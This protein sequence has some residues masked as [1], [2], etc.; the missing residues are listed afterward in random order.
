MTAV[1][2]LDDTICRHENR[3]YATAV[4]IMPTIEKIQRLKKDGWEIIIYSARGQHSCN[5]YLPLIEE[6]NRATV[7]KWLKEHNVPF[8][9]IVFGKP[10]G[11]IYVDDK[12][13]SL[14][15]FLA[16]DCQKFK[17]NSGAEIYRIGDTIIKKCK[18]AK[19]QAKWYKEAAAIGVNVPEVYS[20]VLDGIYTSFVQGESGASRYIG[21]TDLYKLLSTVMLFSLKKRGYIFST[22]AL[23]RRV[24]EHL[25]T[26]RHGY[27][28][29]RLFIYLETNS[30]Y[31]RTQSSMCHGDLSLSN[32]I[33][34]GDRVF[35]IDPIIAERYSSYLMDLAKLRFSLDGGEIFLNSDNFQNY[36][37][38]LAEMDLVLSENQILEKVTALEATYWLRL[39]KYTDDPERKKVVLE[40]AK[41]LEALL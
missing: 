28:F 19:D 2:D 15:D 38:T 3:A 41:K 29:S 34:A 31:Y 27:D 16:S 33:F 21:K 25:S 18:N 37:P 5:G 36:A 6:R 14:E 8:D 17:G 32:T 4:P 11:D 40:K 30:E 1:F 7:E 23:S 20:V 22:E 35:L 24:K 12:G 13:V 26:L 10:L 39:L 9:R